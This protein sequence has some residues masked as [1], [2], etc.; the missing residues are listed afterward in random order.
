[1]LN[2]NMPRYELGMVS[3]SHFDWFKANGN[4]YFIW[5]AQILDEQDDDLY[6]SKA[7]LKFQELLKK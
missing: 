7:K 3:T 6:L 5:L 1:M 4:I 2:R